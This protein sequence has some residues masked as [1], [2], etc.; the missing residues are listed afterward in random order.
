MGYDHNMRMWL[1]NAAIVVGLGALTGCSKNNPGWTVGASG[2]A[3]TEGSTSTGTTGSTATG[4]TSGTS[5]TSTGSTTGEPIQCPLDGSY[6]PFF[7]DVT[8]E[9]DNADALACEGTETYVARRDVTTFFRCD[10]MGDTCDP[11]DC[12]EE[13]I[14]MP[15][16]Y[17]LI[18]GQLDECIIVEH[19]KTWL[20]GTC[21]TRS[22]AAWAADA[23][24]AGDAPQ[25]VLAA[26]APAP[27]PSL[28]DLTIVDTGKRL[29]C[30]CKVA[31]CVDFIVDQ[32][33]WCC[34]G[35]LSLGSVL[36]TNDVGTAY[37]TNYTKYLGNT[38]IR[39][40]GCDYDFFITQGHDGS[41][42][43]GGAPSFQSG[44]FMQRRSCSG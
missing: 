38:P 17:A 39:Y 35:A 1:I 32:E 41:P 33:N 27:P 8:Q 44:W 10:G 14:D 15:E 21:R 11:N 2:G 12:S 19:E 22:L 7:I 3:S 6:C 30:E 18:V 31:G 4:S 36:I 29:E 25:I 34:G 40:R 5:D 16:D 20:N 13:V 28:D 24:P 26:H 42:M 23:S 9:E 37:R 43:C